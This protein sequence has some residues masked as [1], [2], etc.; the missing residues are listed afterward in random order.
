M[1]KS[2]L[3]ISLRAEKIFG[4]FPFY[5]SAMLG[6]GEYLRGYALNRF[7]GDALVAAKADLDIYLFN[8]MIFLPADISL[9]LLSDAG[10][11]FLNGETNS[12]MHY[13]LGGGLNLGYFKRMFNMQFYGAGS[14][15]GAKFYISALFSF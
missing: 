3:T 4:N 14:E 12:K 6:G 15:E 2:N 1:P 10:R 11:V 7:S 8:T 5:E 9:L 13:S